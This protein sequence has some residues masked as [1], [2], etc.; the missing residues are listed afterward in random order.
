MRHT[1]LAAA[2]LAAA[3]ALPLAPD[4][5][6]AQ[7]APGRTITVTGGAQVDAVPEIATVSAGVETRAEVAA[8]A[9]AA[10]STA[11]QAV[12]AA[13]EA[14]GVAKRDMQTSQLNL[15]PVYDDMGQQGAAPKL[16]AYEAS[17]MVTV[18]V[19]DISALGAVIDSLAEAGSNRLFGIGFDITDPQPHLDA[20]REKAVADARHRAELYARAAGVALGPVQSVSETMDMPGPIM[21]RAE[22][23]MSAPVP[24]AEGTV[25]LSA[26]VQ[27]VY[28][29]E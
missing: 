24:V 1:F 5:S 29:I 13:L 26:Q 15:N 7:E 3:L 2:T 10:N 17:N 22:A 18:R 6:H 21:M 19:R 20:A 25:S 23:V 16:V 12:F 9:L 14:A 28:A 27:V 4:A 11:M 8:A